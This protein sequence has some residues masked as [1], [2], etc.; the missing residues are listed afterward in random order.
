MAFIVSLCSLQM[1]S[2]GLWKAREKI[3]GA[4]TQPCF[5]AFTTSKGL[6]SPSFRLT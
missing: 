4:K 3:V 2:R 6:E 5:T 1:L